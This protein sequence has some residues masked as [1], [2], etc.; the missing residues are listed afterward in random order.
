MTAVSVL[1]AVLA[2]L[3]PSL[4]SRVEGSSLPA[5]AQVINQRS[6]NVLNTTQP[7][8]VFN[9]ESLFV[10]PGYTAESL[11]KRPFHVYDEEFLKI[12]G[13]SPTLT[14]IAHSPK[15]PLFHEAV[16]WS[17]ETDEVFFVQNAG[18]KDA[19]TGL[20]KSAIIEKISLADAASV[21]N[22][23]DAAGLVK[24][25]TVPSSPMVINPNGATNYR[26]QFIFTGEGQG[27]NT[28]PALW[29]MNP[30]SPYNTTVLLNNYFG[31]QFNSLNDV[32][33]HPKNKDVYFTDTIYGYV[34]DFRPAPGLQ[35]QVYR[36]NPDSGAVTVVADGFVH[37]NGLTFSPDGEYAY[38]TDTGINY[39]FYG[40]NYTQAASIYRFDVKKDGTL[41]NR[42][43]F[44]FVNAGAPDGVHCDS[45]G[46]VYAGCG[47]GVHVWN[48]SG[49][50]I[51]KIYL[52]TTSA[53]FNFAGKGRMVI[54]AETELYYVTLA[55]DGNYIESEM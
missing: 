26:G 45:W 32:V 1:V 20:H 49:K 23:S 29:L 53:N 31:R 13:K 38:V 43:V 41:D 15:D 30:Q 10:P 34:Q 21:S 55:A 4:S 5:Q 54:C 27:N 19:D 18:A 44:A 46:N 52:G 36:L 6:F 14:R 17:K 35:D 48:P 50:L 37:P 42:K 3:G 25:T 39:G 9:A 33:I 51:G 8:A 22:K 40:M 28:P 47:D 16:V 12:I 24:V 11:V 2:L 7:P